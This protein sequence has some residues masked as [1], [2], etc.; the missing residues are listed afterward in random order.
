M[1]FVI[2][3]S[4]NEGV[5]INVLRKQK[6]GVKTYFAIMWKI[7]RNSRTESFFWVAKSCANLNSLLGVGGYC[8]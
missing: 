1:K 8:I 5:P 3:V 2:H 6:R 4:I 7:L